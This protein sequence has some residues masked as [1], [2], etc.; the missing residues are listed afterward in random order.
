MD[1]KFIRKLF[2]DDIK[3]L[4][5]EPILTRKGIKLRKAPRKL[6]KFPTFGKKWDCP[7][8]IGDLIDDI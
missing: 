7:D 5:K 8:T 3:K 2:H 4:E 1:E 6:V